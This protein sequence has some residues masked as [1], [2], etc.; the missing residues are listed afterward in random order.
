MA[1]AC[2]QLSILG[3]VPGGDSIPTWLTVNV[4]NQRIFALVFSTAYSAANS[5]KRTTPASTSFSAA[6]SAAN[7]PA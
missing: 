1:P 2:E 7:A 4:G 6:Y 3:D 5:R